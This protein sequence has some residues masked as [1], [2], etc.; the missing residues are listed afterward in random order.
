MSRRLRVIAGTA[1]GLL[2][3]APRGGSVRPTTD[4]VKES[5]FGALGT[6]RVDGRAVLDLCAG[7]GALAIESLSRRRDLRRAR[8]P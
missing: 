3:V 4:R 6:E 5:V 2:L 1:G 7:S 8:R